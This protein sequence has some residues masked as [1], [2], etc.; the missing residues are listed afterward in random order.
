MSSSTL[1]TLRNVALA[2]LRDKYPLK[3]S[4]PGITY[5]KE[6]PNWIG[7]RDPYYMIMK[8]IMELCLPALTVVVVV[9]D[10]REAFFLIS[11]HNGDTCSIGIIA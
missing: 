1:Y 4:K 2:K 5:G 9:R 10:V 8:V 3:M 6:L 11:V 7:S